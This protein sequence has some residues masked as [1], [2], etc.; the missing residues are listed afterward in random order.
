MCRVQS[1]TQGV[2]GKVVGVRESGGSTKQGE[3][4]TGDRKTMKS[5]G[6]DRKREE[7]DEE[8]REPMQNKTTEEDIKKGRERVWG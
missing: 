6:I 5:M 2:Q 4:K 7:G 8:L 3:C 1:T